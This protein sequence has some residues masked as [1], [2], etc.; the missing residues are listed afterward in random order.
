MSDKSKW[1]NKK[2]Q[3][4]KIGKLVVYLNRHFDFNN[5]YGW[6]CRIINQN[7][8]FGFGFSSRNKFASYKMAFIDMQLKHIESLKLKGDYDLAIKISKD[9]K[10]YYYE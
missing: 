5:G 9:P 1:L 8:D 3:R 6:R 10:G 4:K 7:G 2:A